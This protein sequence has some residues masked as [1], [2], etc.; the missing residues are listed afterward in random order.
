MRRANIFILLLFFFVIIFFYFQH[1]KRRRGPSGTS[2]RAR[3]TLF[4]CAVFHPAG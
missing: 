4:G 3:R 2:P 1:V